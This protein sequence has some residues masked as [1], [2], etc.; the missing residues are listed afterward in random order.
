MSV[1]ER[2]GQMA[3]Y[4]RELHERRGFCGLGVEGVHVDIIVVSRWL[5]RLPGDPDDG[6]P[7]RPR[8][9]ANYRQ[10]VRIRAVARALGVP[11]PR[12]SSRAA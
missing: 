3:H 7:L 1:R 2:D 10:P 6:R 12:S 4:L 11:V 9:L 8:W 5:W